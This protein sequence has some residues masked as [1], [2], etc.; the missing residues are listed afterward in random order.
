MEERRARKADKPRGHIVPDQV[1][2]TISRELLKTEE[3]ILHQSTISKKAGK[4][5]VQEILSA[6]NKGLD[7]PQSE[8]PDSL[9]SPKLTAKNRDDL[10]KLSKM[11][12]LKSDTKGID[13]GLVASVA[14]MKYFVKNIHNQPKLKN[15][16]LYN[17]WRKKFLNEFLIEL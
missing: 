1:L 11:I 14:D 2:T 12:K 9:K 8:H 13:H 6:V 4:K 7:C 16:K 17:G 15:C 5:Y 3:A 10:E